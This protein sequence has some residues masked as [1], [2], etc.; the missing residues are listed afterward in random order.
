MDR[1]KDSSGQC[2]QNGK[3]QLGHENVGQVKYGTSFSLFSQLEF[4]RDYTQ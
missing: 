1:G 3:Q 2:K 4:Y